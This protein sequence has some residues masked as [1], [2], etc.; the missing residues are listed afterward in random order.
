M[1]TALTHRLP[2]W[3]NDGNFKL[4]PLI[5][6]LLTHT[7]LIDNNQL[8]RDLYNDLNSYWTRA[9]QMAASRHQEGEVYSAQTVNELAKQ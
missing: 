5:D 7:A 9:I 3:E 1:A 2:S 6:T 8:K 4:D